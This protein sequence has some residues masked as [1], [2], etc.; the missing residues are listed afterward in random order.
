MRLL[1]G[2]SNIDDIE[3]VGEGFGTD[4]PNCSGQRGRAAVAS[5]DGLFAGEP[6]GSNKLS[7]T[8]NQNAVAE[9][10][11]LRP[12]YGAEYGK[13]GGAPI[14]LVSQGGD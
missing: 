14:N 8:I 12:N 7:M 10:K 11:V 2:N 4:L 9:V 13:N 3:A 1:P 6:S 5:I